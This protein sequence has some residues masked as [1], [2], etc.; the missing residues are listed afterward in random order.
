MV[1]YSVLIASLNI[2]LNEC[3]SWY[4]RILPYIPRFS[5]ETV[6]GKLLMLLHRP[7]QCLT[8]N[9][10]QLLMFTLPGSVLNILS[11][12]IFS[13]R[14]CS[15]DFSPWGPEMLNNLPKVIVVMELLGCKARQSDSGA[16]TL[17][18]RF[19]HC[20]DQASMNSP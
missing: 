11:C 5:S 17:F 9:S 13:T 15:Q 6:F 10:E 3:T 16:H 14:L 1:Y 4:Q 7:A 12:L 2:N 20:L 8:E 19:C 18:I